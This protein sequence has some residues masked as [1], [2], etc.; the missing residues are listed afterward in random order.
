M[1]KAILQLSLI[2]FVLA[3]VAAPAGAQ[4]K[5]KTPSAKTREITI[6]VYQTEM[7]GR[8]DS[9]QTRSGQTPNR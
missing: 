2:A 1:K 5:I 4:E 8:H 3:S 6:Y 7:D 9:R